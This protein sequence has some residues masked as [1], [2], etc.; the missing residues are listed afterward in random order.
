MFEKKEVRET[1]LKTLMGEAIDAED[2][3]LVKELRQ[4]EKETDHKIFEERMNGLIV[5]YGA[6]ITC[7][8]IG[9]V[10]SK[11]II[12]RRREQLRG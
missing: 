7:V 12:S 3:D 11:V 2:W 9:G 8:I 5:G 4:I 10:V 6:A 1:T